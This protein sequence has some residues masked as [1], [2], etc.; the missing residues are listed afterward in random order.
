MTL[1]QAEH[2][3]K[4]EVAEFWDRNPCG[5]FA[6]NDQPGARRFYEQ[7]ARYRYRSQPFMRKLVGFDRYAGKRLLEV[8]C[9]LGTDLLQFALGGSAV[10]GVDLS[11]Q[12]VSLAAEHFRVF[13]ARGA[14]LSSDAERLPFADGS[15]DI[16]YSF[17]VLHH[18][19]DTQTAIDERW[20]ILRPGGTFKVMLY[21]RRSW[22]VVVEPYLRLAKRRL[23]RQSVRPGTTDKTDVVRQYDG[24]D[25]PL[26]RAYS[27]TEVRRMLRKFVDVNL[28][29]RH[30]LEVQGA[31]IGRI[32]SRLLEW[33]G[34][35]RR[36][37]FWIMA[38]GR[39][40]AGNA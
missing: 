33:S 27:P 20:R 26:G 40:P 14:F 18:T 11:A 10:V 12:R 17:G 32:Y 13:D 28:R 4:Q 35:N 16:V 19:P 15:F 7:V 37:G 29:V 30:P 24:V 8:G 21:N 38:E 1:F 5:S 31:L 22:R 34:I 6:S 39:R 3:T 9:G 23:L 36:W 2:A 25:D